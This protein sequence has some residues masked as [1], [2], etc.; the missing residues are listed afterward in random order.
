MAQRFTG[1]PA[2]IARRGEAADSE[3]AAAPYKRW[4]WALLAIALALGLHV[5][6]S[7]LIQAASFRFELSP[8]APVIAAWAVVRFGPGVVPALLVYALLPRLGWNIGPV[9]MYWAPPSWPAVLV[10]VAAGAWWSARRDPVLWRTLWHS[11]RSTWAMVACGALAFGTLEW[12]AMAVPDVGLGLRIAPA[13]L[14]A[15]LALAMLPRWRTW[16]D[17]ARSLGG[18]PLAMASLMLPPAALL[19]NTGSVYVNASGF[20]LA[21]G[22]IGGLPLAVTVLTA[23]LLWRWPRVRAW[24][25]M[26]VLVIL[27][28]GLRLAAG[29]PALATHWVDYGNG[30]KYLPG[31]SQAWDGLLNALAAGLTVVMLWAVG[32]R[33]AGDEC[34]PVDTVAGPWPGLASPVWKFWLLAWLCAVVSL[35]LPSVAGASQSAF[36]AQDTRGWLV[37]ALAF[38]LGTAYGLRALVWAPSALGLLAAAALLP[39]SGDGALAVVA[40]HGIGVAALVAAWAYVGWLAHRSRARPAP[41]TAV[42]PQAR[43]VAIDGLGRLVHRLDVSATLASFGVLLT[44]L[45]VAVGLVASG[46]TG[47]LMQAFWSAS[48]AFD[49]AEEWPIVALVVVA[50]ALAALLPLS[51]LL[52]DAA[53]R[54]DRTR[55][56]SGLTGAVVF[57][58]LALLTLLMLAGLLGGTASWMVERGAGP[59][60]VAVLAG[61]WASALFATGVGR[62]TGTGSKTV[63]GL[64]VLLLPGVLWAATRLW[65][66]LV[67]TPDREEISQMAWQ[68]AGAA[69]ALALLVAALL[70][71]VRLRADLA[72]PLPRHW[73]FGEIPGGGFWPRLA[74]LMGL[75]ASMWCGSALREPACWLLLIARPLVYVGAGAMFSANGWLGGAVIVA[76]HGSLLAGKYLASRTIWRPEDAEPKP[77]PVLF[78]RG[79][80]DDQ[81]DF[82]LRGFNLLKRWLALW[83][84]RR[85]LDE[86]LVD[87]VG[88][89]GPVVA[90]GR[91]GQS[92]AGFGAA[93]H[94]AR[95][96]DWQ[97][98]V[99]QTARRARAIV[100]AA[101]HTPGVLWEYS[102]LEREGRL[103]R[104]LLLFHT[105]A[106]AAKGNRAAL[107]AFPLPE[108]DRAALMM[109]S[110]PGCWVALLHQGGRWV[111]LTTAEPTPA[112]Y[113]LALRLHFQGA[114]LDTL[115]DKA[116]LL[117]AP[118]WPAWV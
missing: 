84:F 73:L 55:P 104:T 48:G 67:E 17:R 19:L 72:L 5:T 36:F 112:H 106:A 35:V 51:F 14:L 109:A 92:K 64:M 56:V 71:A 44:V 82:R 91:P 18:A 10:G 75:P 13:A 21:W 78:L 117:P 118:R 62:L 22:S 40:A 45:L 9:S 66:D 87:E 2:W 12:P 25:I 116:A 100:M 98:V 31:V 52:V 27:V 42:T 7:Q 102:M 105:G 97:A 43:I 3:K 8:L 15:M 53:N 110:D 77:D 65:A 96:E 86:T 108:L 30:L 94:F 29:W 4:E 85:N 50:S 32:P 59:A 34:H 16:T 58:P 80:D 70:R 47:V 49:W 103:E 26:L 1:N 24:A 60:A 81:F 61:L 107:Q 28:E 41:A 46:A 33:Q 83:S 99:L 79:F 111:L 11:G 39:D 115:A 38:C 37:G 23:G 93:R 63:L 68:L 74:A 90:L 113:V 76:G 95:H 89:Y 57:V 69:L 54:A 114:A 88:R 101:G 6:A 20:W